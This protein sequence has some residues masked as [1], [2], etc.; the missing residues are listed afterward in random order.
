K[1]VARTGTFMTMKRADAQK[2]LREAGATVGSGVTKATDVLIYGDNAGSKL[3]K[4]ASAGVT[5]MTELEMVALLTAGGAGKDQLAGATEKLAQKQA[6][7]AAGATEMT[8]VIAELRTFVQE[9]K[10]RKDITIEH[11]AIGRKAGKSKLL[12]LEAQRAP[13]E[14]IEFYAA[15]D[16]IRV[17]WRSPEDSATGGR[18]RMSPITQWSR[19]TD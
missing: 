13:A 14:L 1:V 5:L 2:R 4:A 12:Q 10:K 9:L 6:E 7:E 19:F 15:M 17:E 16:G 11:A 18:I 8:Q 3:D